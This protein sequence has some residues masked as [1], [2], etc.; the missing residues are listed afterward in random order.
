MISRSIVTTVT[1][2]YREAEDTNRRIKYNMAEPWRRQP[3]FL[4]YRR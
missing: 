1:E 4:S 2:S 3:Q